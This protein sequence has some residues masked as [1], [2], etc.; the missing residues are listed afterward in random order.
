M[1]RIRGYRGLWDEQKNDYCVLSIMKPFKYVCTHTYPYHIYIYI[2]PQD[3]MAQVTDVC[4]NI[5]IKPLSALVCVNVCY[6]FFC[7]VVVDLRCCAGFSPA[8]VHGLRIAVAF[9]VA[10]HRL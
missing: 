6:C 3:G 4:Y 8:A 2:Y 10:A 7:W 1:I 5:R 9:P